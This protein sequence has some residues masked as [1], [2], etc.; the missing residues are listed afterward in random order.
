MVRFIWQKLIHKKWL[1]ICTLLGIILLIGV[2]SGSVLYQ[3]AALNKLLQ[4]KFDRY[5][6]DNNAYPASLKAVYQMVYKKESGAAAE[7]AEKICRTV[8]DEWKKEIP[9]NKNDA[10]MFLA[11]DSLLGIPSYKSDDSKQDLF[12]A[13]GYLENME[14]H[15]RILSGETFRDAADEQGIYECVINEAMAYSYNLFA[16]E[17]IS[18]PK[19]EMKDGKELKIRIAGIFKENDSHDS[20]WVEYPNSYDRTLFISRQ[21]LNEIMSART[22]DLVNMNLTYHV[23]FDYKAM[24]YKQAEA[25]AEGVDRMTAEPPVVKM[26]IT[27]G[28]K[29]LLPA[30]EASM[31]Q[32]KAAMK[33][34]QLPLLVLLLAFLYMV[35]SHVFEMEENEIAMLK[36]RGVNN[37]QVLCIYFLQSFLLAAAGCPAGIFLGVGFASMLGSANAFMEFVGRT[38]MRLSPDAHLPAAVCAAICAAVLFMTLPVIKYTASSVV[39]VKHKKNKTEKSFWQKYYLDVLLVALSLYIRYSLKKQQDVLAQQIIRGESMDPL[40]FLSSVL[41]MLGCGMVFLR[42]LQMLI[43]L[44]Y[45]VGRKGWKPAVYVSFLQIMRTGRKQNFI[46]VFLILTIAMGIFYANTARSMNTSIEERIRYDAGAGMVSREQWKNNLPF[47]KKNK[48]LVTYEEPNFLRYQEL[49]NDGTEKE[50]VEEIT[51]VIRAENVKLLYGNKEIEGNRL[52]AIHTKEFGETAWMKE[53]VL[54]KHWYYYLND[55]SQT[56]NG[57][58]VSSNFRDKMGAQTGDSIK[59]TIYDELGNSRAL[60]TAV[61]CGFVDVWPGY[62]PYQ[63]EENADGSISYRDCYLI[64][65][66]YSQ[67]VSVFG[68]TP[69]EVWYKTE[70]GSDVLKKFAEEKGIELTDIFSV[71]DE[72]IRSKNDAVVQVT[73]GLLTISFLVI[74]ILCMAGF[75]IHWILAIKKR[76]LMF[77]IYRAMGMKMSEVKQMLIHEQI[78]TSLL[79]IAAGAGVGFLSSYLYI[80]LVMTAYLPKKHALAFGVVSTMTDMVRIGA[81]LFVMLTICFAVLT[82]VVSGMKIAQA[83]KLGE[84]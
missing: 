43:R 24:N 81:V 72:L 22:A 35:S 53:N 18:F 19:T 37:G 17:V 33:T 50:T 78:F 8:D 20:Y 12:F 21:A 40:L 69:Y 68:A 75:L 51:R 4:N 70:A 65:A 31:V 46:S 39:E 56:P 11:S 66:N 62:A 13:P 77:G 79:A 73:N 26:T 49:Q 36:S 63:E 82:R 27:S 42:L 76:E 23:L 80:P 5:I 55:I 44:I 45:K 38:G 60:A 71:K 3:G 30:Y 16:G 41:F 61:I 84:D 54:D 15:M 32:V 64:V 57:V 59:Y 74:L 48:K 10:V 67:V 52:M 2:A 47:A 83:L 29:E 7:Q 25:A 28:M 58:L 1:N 34:L 6:G 14:Y 9:M